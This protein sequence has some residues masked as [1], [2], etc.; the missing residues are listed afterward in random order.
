MSDKAAINAAIYALSDQHDGRITPDIVLAAAQS[1]DSPL[2]TAFTWDDGE[3]AHKHRLAEA[4]DL[5]RSV[6]VEVRTTFFT[7]DVPAFVRDPTVGKAQ[8]YASLG[9]LQTEEDAAREAIVAEFSRASAALGRAKAL[10]VALGM[11]DE[12]TEIES[13]VLDLTGR[14]ISAE[15]AA[16]N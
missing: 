5:I 8:G 14:A 13:R 10:A 3:A 2:H 11:A 16:R 4:R 9:R 12:I 6:R 15:A 1:P 7:A